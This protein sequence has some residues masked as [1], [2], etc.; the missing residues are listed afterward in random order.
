MVAPSQSPAR[1]QRLDFWRG[2]CLIDMVLVHLVW[3][4]KVQC[5][6]FLNDF[7]GS[8][9]RF[10]AGGFIFVSGLSIGV[11]FWPRAADPKRRTKTYRALW[12]RSLY[13]LVVNYMCALV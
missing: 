8:Y 10:A 6:P 11:I 12:R 4:A 1:D 13:I 2:L 3:N 7:F 9:T 5:G